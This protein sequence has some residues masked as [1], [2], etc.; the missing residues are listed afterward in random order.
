VHVGLRFAPGL[1][2]TLRTPSR[3][4]GGSSI[5]AA[6]GGCS[7]WGRMFVSAA[8]RRGPLGVHA[9]AHAFPLLRGDELAKL[10]GE[11]NEYGL[12]E[13]I[14]VLERLVLDGR[15]QLAARRIT[16]VEP[17]FEESDGVGS[18]VDFVVSRRSYVAARAKS[19][20]LWKPRC[21]G[22]ASGRV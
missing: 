10:V 7:V 13:P 20:F 16:G 8:A 21:S 3:R 9:A 2:P 19:S 18:P 1:R 5:K 14:V 6:E 12:R 15:N 17:R 22:V 4:E 11:I